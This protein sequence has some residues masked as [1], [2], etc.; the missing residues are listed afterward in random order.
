[1]V[2]PPCN[3]IK[4]PLH[5]SDHLKPDILPITLPP[6]TM[7]IVS[8]YFLFTTVSPGYNLISEKLKLGASV[9]R[10]HMMFAF[11]CLGSSIQ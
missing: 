7:I 1:M 9:Q 11:L 2:Q 8:F 3:W 6:L 4:I 10:E 5:S